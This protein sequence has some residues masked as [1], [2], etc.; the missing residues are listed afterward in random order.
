MVSPLT[1]NEELLYR[2]SVL[3]GA[4]NGALHGHQLSLLDQVNT[5]AETIF[6]SRDNLHTNTNRNMR[7][8]RALNA[9]I[10][11]FI[12]SF[13][14]RWFVD[15]WMQQTPLT[16]TLHRSL[17]HCSQWAGRRQDL[18]HSILLLNPPN[19]QQSSRQFL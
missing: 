12:F 9:Q 5:G 17:L 3:N 4:L 8:T 18:D 15:S 10:Q 6:L 14:F 1:M 11:E 7:D 16:C 2:L 13:L 19:P